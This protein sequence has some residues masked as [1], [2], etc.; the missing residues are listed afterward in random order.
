MNVLNVWV[1][2][3][4][5]AALLG[6][7]VFYVE[8]GQLRLALASANYLYLLPA[9]GLL[10]IGFPIRAHRWSYLISPL[11]QIRHLSLLS[12]TC[13]G[14][15][16]NMLFPARLGEFARAYI[17][18]EKE[19]I[20]KA[21]SLATIV[22]E[23]LWDSF[24]ILFIFAVLLMSVSAPEPFLP[25]WHALRTAGLMLFLFLGFLV[26]LLLL[27]KN[28]PEGASRLLD[29]VLIL[30]PTGLGE[31][32]KLFLQAFIDG[33][34]A[35]GIGRHLIAIAF[36]SFLLW[37]TGIMFNYMLLRAFGLDLPFHAAVFLIVAQAL[38]VAIPSGPGFIGTFH[39]ATVAGLTLFSVPIG[40]ALGIA[41]V[42]HA[43]VF[44]PTVM[45]GLLFL[46]CEGASLNQISQVR[47][48][49][50]AVR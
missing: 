6:L 25:S 50:D 20:S 10:L 23:R 27:L 44:V 7:A 43:V 46:W 2:I 39:A 11:K 3:V 5:S 18:G 48:H 35:M 41:I 31:K 12:A 4:V 33:L 16:C 8:L 19:G 42:A 1:G 49:V 14:F 15:M 40:Q 13:I 9:T 28:Q 45:A 21:A 26:I 47:V 34:G 30:L 17:I 32:V 36:Y 37:M 38:G 29:S 22:V 24:S